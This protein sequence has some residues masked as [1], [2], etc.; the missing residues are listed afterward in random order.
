MAFKAFQ[1][2][3]TQVH[4]GNFSIYLVNIYLFPA[5]CIVFSCNGYDLVRKEK[6]R[7]LIKLLKTL[8]LTHVPSFPVLSKHSHIHHLIFISLLCALIAH[9]GL[10][11]ASSVPA[12]TFAALGVHGFL[13]SFFTATICSHQSY[14]KFLFPGT[15]NVLSTNNFE[16]P[17]WPAQRIRSNVAFSWSLFHFL[18]RPGATIAVVHLRKGYKFVGYLLL[19]SPWQVQTSNTRKQKVSATALKQ[20]RVDRKTSFRFIPNWRNSQAQLSPTYMVIARSMPNGPP[21]QI[22]FLL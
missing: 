19:K 21:F 20:F 5:L 14:C 10:C 2:T 16:N 3:G 1:Q 8:L 4:I 22:S 18:S 9:D 13:L 17:M 15:Y 7:T 12:T 6:C 11:Q